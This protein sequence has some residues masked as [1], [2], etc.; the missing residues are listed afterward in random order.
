M[1]PSLSIPIK[2]TTDGSSGDLVALDTTSSE[3][4]FVARELGVQRDKTFQEAGLSLERFP[5]SSDEADLIDKLLADDLEKLSFEEKERT[6]FDIHGMAHE[7]HDPENIDELLEQLELEIRKIPDRKAY[8]KAKYLNEEY[9]IGREFR[10]MFLR[11]DE[12]D[13]KASAQRIVTHFEVKREVFGDGPALARKLC[14]SDL[15]EDDMT[16]LKSGAWQLLPVRDV[17]GR[18]VMLV[19]PSCRVESLAVECHLRAIM[20]FLMSILQTED[21]QKKGIVA[22]MWWSGQSLL[23]VQQNIFTQVQR[24]KKLRPGI[25]RKVSGIHFLLGQEYL[26]PLVGGIRWFIHEHLRARTRVHFGDFQQLIFEL[27]TFGIPTDCLPFNANG[28]MNL[29]NHLQWIQSRRKQE[30]KGNNNTVDIIVPRRFD[31]L[32]GRGHHT[33]NHTG[34]L[35]AAHIADMFRDK[36]EAAG[37]YEKTA[38]AERIV[39]II[40]ES[41]GRFLKWEDDAWVEVDQQTARNKISHFYRNTRNKPQSSSPSKNK[42]APSSDGSV[43]GGSTGSDGESLAAASSKRMSPEAVQ[44]SSQRGHKRYQRHT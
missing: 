13:V 31:V 20:F 32:F 8:E 38:I 15:N 42:A 4:D 26:R 36:Y 23:Q 27:Q 3:V 39:K 2:T 16:V 37:K 6:A 33:R 11:C 18:L 29:E 34:N 12:F 41:Q 5:Q 7:Y 22:V 30:E 17:A 25:P 10:L 19:S 40:R 44:Q 24:M 43:S 1:K 21:A 35:R 9:V 14:M 28:P